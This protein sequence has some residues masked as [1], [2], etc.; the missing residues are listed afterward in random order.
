MLGLK[1]FI[2]MFAMF[3]HVFSHTCQEYCN[4]L[5]TCANDPQAHGSYCKSWQNPPVCFGIYYVDAS[6]STKCFQPADPSC[7]GTIP[8]S[9]PEDEFVH[10]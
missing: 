1:F 2:T 9:C 4:D 3:T 6:R 7:P 5:P 8:V 10:L